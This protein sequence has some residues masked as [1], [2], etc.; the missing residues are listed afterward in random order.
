MQDVIKEYLEDLRERH[1]AVEF[2]WSVNLETNSG[3]QSVYTVSHS[4]KTQAMTI[5]WRYKTFGDGSLGVFCA[6]PGVFTSYWAS[7]N[8]PKLSIQ[9]ALDEIY[10]SK[11]L[12]RMRGLDV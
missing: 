1:V 7:P 2:D 8:S 3:D 12:K 11:L 5:V 4:N 9:N 6:I 10:E